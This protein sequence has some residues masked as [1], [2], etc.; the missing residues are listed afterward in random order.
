MSESRW[1]E[2]EEVAP[3][4]SSENDRSESCP[5]SDVDAEV[6]I[7]ITKQY[8]LFVHGIREYCKLI[9]YT[10]IIIVNYSIV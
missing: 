6:E 10:Y 9:Q 2:V 8:K 5:A 7:A 4:I 1:P 3:S